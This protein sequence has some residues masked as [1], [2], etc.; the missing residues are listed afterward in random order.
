MSVQINRFQRIKDYNTF[1]LLVTFTTA[2]LL[3]MLAISMPVLFE[4]CFLLEVNSILVYL[5]RV[6]GKLN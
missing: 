6:Q 2:I 3:G 1:N 4:D 5:R